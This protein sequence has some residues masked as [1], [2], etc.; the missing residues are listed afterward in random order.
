MTDVGSNLFNKE[1]ACGLGLDID[2][3]GA[4]EGQALLSG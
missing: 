3:V 1:G 4:E 2:F